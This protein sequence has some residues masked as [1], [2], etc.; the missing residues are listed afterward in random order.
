MASTT[1]SYVCSSHQQWVRQKRLSSEGC[2]CP[3]DFPLQLG[4]P[5][6]LVSLTL[7]PAKA[8]IKT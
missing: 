2:C 4:V 6:S 3:E 7:L 8:Q 5:C 1:P